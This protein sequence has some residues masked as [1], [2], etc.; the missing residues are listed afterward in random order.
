MANRLINKDAL[1]QVEELWSRCFEKRGTPFFE[2]YFREYALRQN[3]IF[4]GFD[5]ANRLETM[6][7]INPYSIRLRGR[8][9]KVPYLVGVAADPL[10]RGRG[11][12][13]ELMA[14]AFDVLRAMGAGLALLMPVK[15]A[16]YK[17]YGFAFTHLTAA[18]R[19]PLHGL[20]H[21][22]ADVSWDLQRLGPLEAA[23]A[24]PAVYDRA[25]QRYNA[26]C[27]RDER[28]WRNIL[29]VAA[30]EQGECVLALQGEEV[31]GYCLYH[32]EGTTLAVDELLAAEAGGRN[33]LLGYLSALHEYK[34]LAWNAPADDLSYLDFADQEMAP[35]LRP[36]IMGRII[37]VE[38][39]LRELPVPA[40]VS[41]SMRLLVFD[42]FMG[43]NN[44]RK[45]LRVADGEIELRD[46]VE[47][48]D[49]V[50]DIRSLTQLMF[51][52]YSL[53][54]LRQA[55]RI[56]CNNGEAG[57]LLSALLPDRINYFNEQF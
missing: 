17:P 9:L 42:D 38:K 41:G 33:A 13:E 29:E 27:L 30:A 2:W 3:K 20:G 55:G 8:T 15:A 6:L 56:Q 19:M 32:N 11:R 50:L 51:G 54:A 46:T 47:E 1:P 28:V 4:C 40:A 16:I 52:T 53:E 36:A 5:F 45:E 24:L 57:K 21:I 37:N 48:P 25:M 7:H 14:S 43:L 31:L 26:C 34:D 35:R 44:I 10:V 39:V 12:M 18:Y 22:P 49:V 23:A